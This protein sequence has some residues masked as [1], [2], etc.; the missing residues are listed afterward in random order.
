LLELIDEYEVPTDEEVEALFEYLLSHPK[1]LLREF[2][3]GMT[4]PSR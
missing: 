2:L 3:R 4:S 1:R